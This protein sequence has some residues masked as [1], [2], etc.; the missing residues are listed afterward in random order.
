MNSHIID[1]HS[2]YIITLIVFSHATILESSL[3]LERSKDM[4][5]TRLFSLSEGIN[6]VELNSALYNQLSSPIFQTFRNPIS[7]ATTKRQ[8]NDLCVELTNIYKNSKNS[9]IGAR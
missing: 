1:V 5:N 4:E 6:C 8:M 3:P 2:E 9:Q 7:E